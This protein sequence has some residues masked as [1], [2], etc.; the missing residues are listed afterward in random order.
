[1]CDVKI[2]NQTSKSAEHAYQ[3]CK[4]SELLNNDLAEKIIKAPYA[5]DA[6][7]LGADA[8]SHDE[9]QT[10]SKIIHLV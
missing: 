5:K 6:K 7:A 9:M 1:M 8:F 2:W 3:W 4:A 10:W